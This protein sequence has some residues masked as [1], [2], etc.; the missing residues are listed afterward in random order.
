[1]DLWRELLIGG[2]SEENEKYEFINDE[3]IKEIIENKC[4]MVLLQ[5]KKII[6]EEKLSD[7]DCFFK[8]EKLLE[9]L[10]KN[11]ISCDRHDFG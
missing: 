6:E 5:I 10:E 8:I 1:M 2:L 3:T 9:V 11:E 7:K 4:Y